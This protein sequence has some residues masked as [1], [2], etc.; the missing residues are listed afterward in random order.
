M[1]ATINYLVEANLGLL[2]SLAFYVLVLKKETRFRLLRVYL[3]T[4]IAVSLLFP[5]VDISFTQASPLSISRVIPSYWLPEITVGAGQEVTNMQQTLPP[6]FWGYTS[7]VYT[8]GLVLFCLAICVQLIRL[9]R[10]IRNASTYSVDKLR[11]AESNED[12][13]TF[14]FFNFIFIGKANAFSEEEKKQIIL[15]ESVHAR[16]GHS[17]DILLVN[18][19]KIFFWFNPFINSYK[20]IFV[21]LHEFEA[22]ARAVENTD[23]NG[24]CSLLARVALQSA[25]LRL[26]N[27]FNNSLTI[28]R[29]EMMRTIK[30]NIKRWK[31]AAI[32]VAL[33]CLFFFIACQDQVE[34]DLISI[35]KNSSHALMVP[36]KVQER[37]DQL[38]KENPGKNYALLQLNQTASEKLT[39]LKDK[40]G[41]PQ[42]VEVFNTSTKSAKR[43]DQRQLEMLSVTAESG[44]SEITLDESESAMAGETFAIIEFTDQASRLSDAAAQDDQIY[45]VVEQQPEFPGGYDS[46]MTFIRTHLR[47]PLEARQQGIEGTVYASFIVDKEGAVSSVNIIRG[48]SPECDNAVRHLVESSPN[49][50]PGKQSGRAVSVRF[51]LPIKFKL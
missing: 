23:V 47:Y 40:Y 3:L 43:P 51:V 26:A 48:L 28:K 36:V 29:I 34:D 5:L 16:Q 39:E 38:K 1:N 6:D 46:M 18:V 11:I 22:D 12:K 45:T 19:L 15:H 20:K 31:W 41:T 2:I 50:K 14:S 8:I 32:A 35:T 13:P 27:Y 42:H 49:W 25:N 10:V 7:L 44:Y 9:F 17:F 21:Q 4:A 37:Y 33:P 24:Y 30:T